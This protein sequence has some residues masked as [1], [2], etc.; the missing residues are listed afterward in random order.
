MLKKQVENYFLSKVSHTVRGY[1][2]MSWHDIFSLAVREDPAL[3][4][5]HSKEAT[6]STA[7]WEAGTNPQA[8]AGPWGLPEFLHNPFC[9]HSRAQIRTETHHPFF[10][11]SSV[12]NRGCSSKAN[13]VHFRQARNL[14]LSIVTA[15]NYFQEDVGSNRK[16]K[17]FQYYY[18]ELIN[19]LSKINA[20]T[21]RPLISNMDSLFCLLE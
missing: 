1:A 6:L 10:W 15:R 2:F 9:K 16:Y 3:D 21:D 13:Y 11:A 7:V 17:N 18:L 20:Q 5:I 4:H 19:C 14:N 12:W 8:T